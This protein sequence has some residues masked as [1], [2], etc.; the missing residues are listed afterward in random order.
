MFN[1][2]SSEHDSE[3]IILVSVL[4]LVHQI[5]R[6]VIKNTQDQGVSFTH[7]LHALMDAYGNPLRFKITISN[8]NDITQASEMIDGIECSGSG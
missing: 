3:W 4:T 5:I 2:F 7:K 8:R 6:L 1:Y